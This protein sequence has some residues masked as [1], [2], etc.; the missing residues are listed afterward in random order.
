MGWGDE[1]DKD[2]QHFEGSMRQS[3]DLDFNVATAWISISI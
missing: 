3:V 2:S 1:R